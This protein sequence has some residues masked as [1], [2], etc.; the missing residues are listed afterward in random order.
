M[1]LELPDPEP[2]WKAKLREQAHKLALIKLQQERMRRANQ[3][4]IDW[5][6]TKPPEILNTSIG[7]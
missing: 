2:D 4:V 6:E 5:L 7:K 3:E 1:K